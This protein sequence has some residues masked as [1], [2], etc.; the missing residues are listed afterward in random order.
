MA[1]RPSNPVK[2]LLIDI[3]GFGL[4]AS[5]LLFSW[6]PGPGGIPLAIAGLSVLAINHDWAKRWQTRAKEG[7]LNLTNKIFVDHPVVK[8]AL[9]ILGATL[10]VLAVVILNNFTQNMYRTMA[11][12][13]AFMGLGL[14]LGNR[15]R[16]Q[17]ILRVLRRR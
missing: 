10:V 4:L 11:V 9:D 17:R 14:F 3:A 1:E 15:N 2:R 6:V 16:L 13:A 8:W 5:A 12:S 7:G